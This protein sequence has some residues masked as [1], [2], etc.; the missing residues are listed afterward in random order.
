MNFNES[1]IVGIISCVVA[2]LILYAL[3]IVVQNIKDKKAQSE[4]NKVGKTVEKYIDEDFLYNYE[5]GNI[6]IEKIIEDF[7]QPQNKYDDTNDFFKEDSE[8]LYQLTI[9]KYNFT[10]AIVL[11]STLKNE[12]SIISVTINGATIKSHLVKCRFSFAEEDQYFGEAKITNEVL[13]NKTGFWSHSFI[14]WAFAVIQAR[15]FYPKIKHLNFTYIVCDSNIDE[16]EILGK[17]VDQ[18]CV[19][20]ISSVCPFIYFYDMI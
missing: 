4:K 14:N 11:F 9:Y 15:Y 3:Q 18:L 1:L 8:T 13:E 17:S 5:P 12:S 2:G 6:I 20:A 7:G 19:S 16:N 10:N